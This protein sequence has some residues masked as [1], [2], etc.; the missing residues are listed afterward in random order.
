M[1]RVC[2]YILVFVAGGSQTCLP[3]AIPEGQRS[4]ISQN[5]LSMPIG[6]ASGDWQ[7]NLILTDMME[8]LL[9]EALGYNVARVVTGSGLFKLLYVAGCRLEAPI[10][11]SLP[12]FHHI[13]L[14]VMVAHTALT[15]WITAMEQ[16]GDEAPVDLGSMGYEGTEGLFVFQEPRTKY[17]ADT[18]LDLSYFF[19][20]NASWFH[21]ENY[22]ATV[23]EVDMSQ[24]RPCAESLHVE[25]PGLAQQ[26][27][28]VTGDLDGIEY[29][30]GEAHLICWR[31][32]WWL[33]PACRS[34]ASNCIAVVTGPEAWGKPYMVQ[35]AAFHNM[36]LALASAVSTSAYQ[37]IT[38]QLKSLFY[39][40]TPDPSFAAFQ[41]SKVVFPQHNAGEYR[42][43]VYKTQPNSEPMRKLVSSGLATAASR[44][45]GLVAN[46]YFLE[47]DVS[48][49]L[50]LH[51]QSGSN[52]WHT[53]CTWLKSHGDQWAGWIPAK[54]DCTAG[55]GLV[56]ESGMFVSAGANA[57]DCA[58]C[59]PGRASLKWNNT[60]LCASCPVGSFQNSWGA[61]ECSLCDTGAIA[62]ERGATQCSLCTLGQFANGTG[63]SFCFNCTM[64]SG[65]SGQRELWTTSQEVIWETGSQIIQVQG[66]T[67][68]SFCSCTVGSFLK[69]GRCVACPVG[70][71]CPGSNRLE[72]LPGYF[73]SPDTP[74][75]VY[76]C[77][78]S[79][80]PGGPPGT[81][82]ENR[83]AESVAC[84]LCLG[85]HREQRDG[86]CQ[87]C[88]DSD[89]MLLLLLAAGIVAGVA[90]LYVSLLQEEQAQQNRHVLV[91]VCGFSQ[92]LA[93]LQMLAVIKRFDISWGEPFASFLIYSDILSLDF[94]MVSFTC[95]TMGP[96]ETFALRA[97]T[98]PAMVVVASMV[99]AAHKLTAFLLNGA[100][101]ANRVSA[102]YLLRTVG[103]L[104]LM[105]FII[106][107]SMLLAPFKCRA[108]PNGRF[109]VQGYG[110]VLCNGHGQ[111]M[112]LFLIGGLACMMP[113]LFLSVCIWLVL[114]ELPRR[115][116]RSDTNFVRTCS[117]LIVRFRPGAEVFAVV[118]L[119]RNAVVVLCPIVSTNSTKLLMM[120]L[121]LY[122]NQ[123]L[124]A[125]FRPWRFALC[126]FLDMVIVLGMLVIL[127]MGSVTVRDSDHRAT[128]AVVVIFLSAMLL[129]FLCLPPRTE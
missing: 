117:F 47:S 93:M 100:A 29:R 79:F 31:D 128:T 88:S 91:I 85:G 28:S 70:T 62:A 38:L 125:L 42:E 37:Q 77:E 8:I 65:H 25:W 102:R 119:I 67:S 63:M 74:D 61:T 32:T 27:L 16:L 104:F 69:E 54:T 58:T 34:N 114:V 50:A 103:S 89:Y 123:L 129:G 56:D 36:P 41:T 96:V 120:S 22:L 10:T 115:L 80:C 81:C 113:L 7:F 105:F 124:V 90:A 66:A 20:Y 109:T 35:Q 84:T 2:C 30:N 23:D 11:C 13:T 48:D 126:N 112:Q 83:D 3:G 43:G 21:P 95:V 97:L 86:S 40:W 82:A 5:G 127:D 12:S 45:N 98:M 1:F 53:A 15:E 60:F 52:P 24:L 33:A 6:I 68:S 87:P 57:A 59:P 111:H 122:A 76:L 46:F 73:S 55:K 9:K 72:L 106:L 75:D 108:H 121:V 116:T 118:L 78:E 26:Y 107:F 110:S 71:H 17:L 39:W 19:S 44:A 49:L 94:E 18:G 51:V 4:N 14:E 99:Y 101:G 64:E 92:F